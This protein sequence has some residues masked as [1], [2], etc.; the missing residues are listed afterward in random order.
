MEQVVF[1]KVSP[2]WKSLKL[3]GERN[4]EVASV[5]VSRERV[6]EAAGLVQS[7]QEATDD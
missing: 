7:R 5:Q 2:S 4:L 6:A 3:P 1:T